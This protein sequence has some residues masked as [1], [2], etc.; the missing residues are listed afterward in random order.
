MRFFGRDT[1]TVSVW[2]AIVFHPRFFYRLKPGCFSKA[3]GQGKAN[4]SAMQQP[5][6]FAMHFFSF[7]FLGF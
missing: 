4:F 5:G 7:D 2:F 6:P 1:A 3:T